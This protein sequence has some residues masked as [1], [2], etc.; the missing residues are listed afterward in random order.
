MKEKFREWNFRGDLKVTYTDETGNKKIWQKNQQ[1]LLDQI[2]DIVESYLAQGLTL[3]NRQLYYQLVSKGFIPNADEIYKRICTFLT[4]ARYAGLIDWD[5][6]ED[7]GRVPHK[8]LEF[9]NIKERI[10]LAVA[11]YRLPRWQ[12][13]EYYVELYC[14][15]QGM[16]NVLKPVADK[17]HICFGSNKGYSSASTMYD[18]AERIAG[19]IYE[20]KK[21]VI[22]YLGDH[23]PSGLD[24]VRDIGSRITEFLISGNDVVDILG[25]DENNPC[26][27]VVPLALNMGQ[28]KQ[29][30]P[31]P[32]PAKI[33]DPRAGWYI[34]KFGMKSWEL[35]A[36]EPRV[37]VEIAE[38]GVEDFLDIKKYNR[39]ILQERQEKKSLEAFGESLLKKT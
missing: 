4:D 29:Y 31:P 38:N 9:N 22:L 1:E 15:K 33:K 28:I 32:N 35:D 23:D 6:I 21:S 12:D 37:L 20:G 36:L 19:K 26:L 16:E 14:E 25:D 11:N 30:N 5:A 13:Q 24:M 17:Y 10:D 2:V 8:P 27:R 7:R 3:T 18:L 39:W 34:Q